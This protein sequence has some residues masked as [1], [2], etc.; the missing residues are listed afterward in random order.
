MINWEFYDFQTW[1][2]KIG[3]RFSLEMWIVEQNCED[4]NVGTYGDKV[5]IYDHITK[6]FILL[7]NYNVRPLFWSSLDERQDSHFKIF[8]SPHLV[9]VMTR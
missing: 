8:I 5:V 2:I 7:Q 3:T 4:S 9:V 6:I 1:K